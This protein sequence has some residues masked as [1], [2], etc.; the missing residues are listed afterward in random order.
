MNIIR[1]RVYSIVAQWFPTWL[2]GGRIAKIMKKKNSLL[3][4]ENCI[5]IIII[6]QLETAISESGRLTKYKF[7]VAVRKTVDNHWYIMLRSIV[8]VWLVIFMGK[9][10]F[11]K[12]H[13]RFSGL[14]YDYRKSSGS[15]ERYAFRYDIIFFSRSVRRL[16]MFSVLYAARK[17][18]DFL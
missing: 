17:Q 13:H 5:I 16:W 14:P 10:K 11:K 9:K 6:I 18:Y 15:G 4:D 2:G 7:A 8:L 3:S 12:Y 1:V